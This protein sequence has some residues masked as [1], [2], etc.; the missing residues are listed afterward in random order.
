MLIII[1][2][3]EWNYDAYNPKEYTLKWKLKK[4]CK[5]PH[6]LIVSCT[7]VATVLDT[8]LRQQNNKYTTH[9]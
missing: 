8:T 4:Y 1:F 6:N 3:L 5:K 2:L 7:G 9:N